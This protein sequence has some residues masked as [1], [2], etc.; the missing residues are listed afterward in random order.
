[1]FEGT[2]S[3][4][5]GQ[6]WLVKGQELHLDRPLLMGILNVTSD[7][8]SDG[9][10]Y[11]ESDRAISRAQEMLSQGAAIIDVGGES[12]RPGSLPVGA[13][14]ETSRVVPVI[15]ELALRTDAIIS[16]DTQKADVARAAMDAGAHIVNDISAGLN[17][18]Q[19]LDLV[20]S[21]QM[22]IIM[23]HMQGTPQ[24]MQVSPRYDD[25]LAEVAAFFE[26]RL[27]VA[28][29][30]GIE[31]DRILLDPGIGFGKTLEDNLKLMGN[32]EK[33]NQ[34]G[35]PL[36]LGASRKSFI[37]MLDDSG[38]DHRLGGSLA[39]VVTAYI[40]GVRLFRVHDVA[41]TRQV[42][43]IFTAIQMHSD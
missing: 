34:A 43:D 37:G 21:S 17:D 11:S 8:F 29:T 25:V 18:P 38:V 32:L 26:D 30:K 33:L 9:G 2:M 16:V 39:A 22:G 1:M 20:A 23:M 5:I 36:L 12:S 10:Q 42:L 14:E 4:G 41:E 7:S 28:T 15:K 24:T 19:M 35:R 6:K 3:R 31:Q 40:Q 13:E 27:R